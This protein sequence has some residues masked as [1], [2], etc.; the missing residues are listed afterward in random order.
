[1]KN[2][3]LLFLLGTTFSVTAQKI[4]DYGFNKVRIS[5]G[6]KVIQAELKPVA[7]TPSVETDRFYYWYSSNIIHSTQ[8]GFSGKLLNGKY[9]EY[10][11]NKN[12]QEEGVFK[13][14]LK[15]NIWKN[16]DESGVLT[17]IYTWK[18]GIKTGEFSL[19][20]PNGNLKQTGN[21]NNNLLDGKVK[22]YNESGTETITTYHKGTLVV[23]KPSKF[24]E[25]LNFFKK[26]AKKNAKQ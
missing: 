19:F 5:A 3:L 23:N 9:T 10:Y 20:Y 22:S 16:W 14:G 8:G 21:Y 13:K 7:S 18:N 24:W 6:D 26:K 25:K 4:P 12:I 11:L 17:Q 2:I 1:M 15:D